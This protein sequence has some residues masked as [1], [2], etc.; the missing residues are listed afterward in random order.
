MYER[1]RSEASSA[2]GACDTF[3]LRIEI[4]EY[5]YNIASVIRLEANNCDG[6]C[7]NALRT[8]LICITVFAFLY[9]LVSVTIYQ[10]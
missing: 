7:Q 3:F 8:S 4:G 1:H 6:S 2:R 10:R 9:R 5:V